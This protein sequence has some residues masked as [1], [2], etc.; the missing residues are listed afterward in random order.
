[1]SY[2]QNPQTIIQ[3]VPRMI[4]QNININMSQN[5]SQRGLNKSSSSPGM[6]SFDSKPNFIFYNQNQSQTPLNNFQ[7]NKNINQNHYFIQKQINNINIR[8]P[9]RQVNQSQILQNRKN[10]QDNS[11]NSIFLNQTQNP[12]LNQ[13]TLYQN[14]N[15]IFNH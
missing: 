8:F 11:N 7:Q 12:Y 3:E 5:I 4:N 14:T 1:M 10:S 15:Q 9:I 2:T 13:N 6:A